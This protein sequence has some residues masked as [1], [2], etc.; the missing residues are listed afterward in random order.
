MSVLRVNRSRPWFLAALGCCAGLM[1]IASQP[2]A[3][4][5]AKAGHASHT[6]GLAVTDWRNALVLTP[7]AEECSLGEQ[8]GEPAQAR[9]QEGYVDLLKR[10]G[11]SYDNRGPNGEMSQYNPYLVQ[12]PLPFSELTTKTGYGFNLDGT[13]DGH[14]TTKTCAHEKFT[15]P[16]GES[17]DYQLARVTGCVH[18]FRI[19][20]GQP[21]FGSTEVVT[22]TIN[23]RLIEITGVDDEMNDP[24]VEITIYKGR[25]AIVRTPVENKFVAYSSQRIDGRFPQYNGFKAH[26]KIVNGVLISEPFPVVL[27]AKG[28]TTR[29]VSEYDLKDVRLRLKLTEDGAEGLLG[30]YE[31][32]ATWWIPHSKGVTSGLSAYSSSSLYKAFMRYADGYPDATGQ[33]TRISVTYRVRAVR[34]LIVH[35]QKDQPQR[36]RHVADARE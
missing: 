32:L 26:G 33:C 30:G 21:N 36:P 25:D 22:S 11:G 35:N 6:I 29:D 9:A 28:A 27:I 20:D 14:A 24:D 2:A 1:A 31:S 13:S 7:N 23:R 19:P 16:E 18:G 15:S 34:A 4:A 12:D 5:E 8:K 10:Y 3:A 17:V